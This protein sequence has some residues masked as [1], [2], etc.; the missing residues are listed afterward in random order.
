[1][2]HLQE[3][4]RG[5]SV[6]AS[7]SQHKPVQQVSLVTWFPF[8]MLGIYLIFFLSYSHSV[9]IHEILWLEEGGFWLASASC[10]LR[11][12]RLH[13]HTLSLLPWTSPYELFPRSLCEKMQVIVRRYISWNQNSYTY[14]ILNPV[15]AFYRHL[16]QEVVFD[17][18]YLNLMCWW[19][20]S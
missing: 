3:E 14:L 1:M 16:R 19:K 8:F 20:W 11:R 4:G 12:L 17:Y 7:R 6:V 2:R 5:G 15:Y 13:Q 10:W 9:S 18:I